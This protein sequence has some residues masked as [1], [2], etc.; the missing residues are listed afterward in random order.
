MH[1]IVEFSMKG[2]ILMSDTNEP[3]CQTKQGFLTTADDPNRMLWYGM[4]SY[5]TDDWSK[6]SKTGPGI[7]VCPCCK[8]PG[9]IENAQ[10]WL[11]A[12]MAYEMENSDAKGYYQFILDNKETCIPE[13]KFSDLFDEWKAKQADNKKDKT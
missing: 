4:C 13:K 3:S 1:L 11:S 8:T 9:F 6:L 5:W 7:P 2:M 12:A 10:E